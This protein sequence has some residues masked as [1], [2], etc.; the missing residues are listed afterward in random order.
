MHRN[1]LSTAVRIAPDAF[2]PKI[3]AHVK[4]TLDNSA[5]MNITRD[6]FALLSWPEGELYDKSVI[7]RWGVDS[8]VVIFFF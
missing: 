8:F 7:E 3:V 1:M 4:S 2:M 6:E 5:L